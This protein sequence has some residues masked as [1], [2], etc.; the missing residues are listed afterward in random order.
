MKSAENVEIFAYP[1][2]S[3][4]MPHIMPNPVYADVSP[5][6]CRLWDSPDMGIIRPGTQFAI[7]P[8]PRTLEIA[9]YQEVTS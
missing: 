6:E 7:L 9:E 3:N 4:H 5:Q 2:S 8:M 1:L